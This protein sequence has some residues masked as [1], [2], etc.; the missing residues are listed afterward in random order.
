M[1]R[2]TLE[3]C[4]NYA[5]VVY[6]DR[7]EPF[8]IRRIGCTLFE[9]SGY[10]PSFPGSPEHR[11]LI[12]PGLKQAAFAI[13]YAYYFDYD[14]Q[15]LYELEHVWVYVD[16]SGSVC[17]CEGSFHGKYLNEMIPLFSILDA[18]STHVRLYSQPG[19]HAFLPAI[20]LFRLYPDPDACCMEDAGKD[21]LSLPEMFSGRVPD[22]ESVQTAVRTFI[23]KQYAFKPSWRFVPVIPDSGLYISWDELAHEIPQRIAAELSRIGAI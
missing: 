19:K 4:L 16:H 21:G 11:R 13:E 23:K 18:G 8:A 9:K 10:S 20:E 22:T 5:P 2:K 3:T 1:D 12:M 17:G 7:K 6:F 15:H 14:I